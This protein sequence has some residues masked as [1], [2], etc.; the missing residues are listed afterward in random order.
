MSV[1][2]AGFEPA[3]SDVCGETLLFGGVLGFRLAVRARLP[4]TR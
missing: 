1:D 2:S 3:T 4:V